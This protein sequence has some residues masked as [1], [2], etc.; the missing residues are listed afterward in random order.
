MKLSYLG[1][2]AGLLVCS[3]SAPAVA[4][5][6]D[7]HDR[8]D[9]NDRRDDRR[10]DRDDRRDGRH[11]YDRNKWVRISTESFEGRGDREGAS[12][13]WA[14]HRVRTVGLRAD[15]DARCSRISVRLG[16]GDRVDLTDRGPR[17]L[18]AGEF[19]QY[20]LPGRKRDIKRLSL[21]CHAQGGGRVSIEIFA[22]K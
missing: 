10:S 13:G 19:V 12:G 16:N 18:R 15:R 1:I 7:R 22:L 8:Y 17:R 11:G 21:S 14:G 3:L 6:Y 20:D 5:H 9:R 2:L 4:Q